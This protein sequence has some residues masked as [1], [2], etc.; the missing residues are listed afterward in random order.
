MPNALASANS[1]L[2][3]LIVH[4]SEVGGIRR[5]V[6]GLVLAEGGVARLCGV[7]ARLL[8]AL[9]ALLADLR[10]NDK[11][12]SGDK[13]RS[14]ETPRTSHLRSN[15]AVFVYARFARSFDASS[16]AARMTGSA[17]TGAVW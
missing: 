11:A 1:T 3:L 14:T 8:L 4:P 12:M 17:S 13:D 6:E 15:V 5:A 2:P 9:E 7:R 16:L 10:S